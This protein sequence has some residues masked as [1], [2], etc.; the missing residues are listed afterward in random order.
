M[1]AGEPCSIIPG[2]I[3]AAIR[4]ESMS[5]RNRGDSTPEISMTFVFIVFFIQR[6]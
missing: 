6:A 4:F 5:E 1:V 3:S 2:I